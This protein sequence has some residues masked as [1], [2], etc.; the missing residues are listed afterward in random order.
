MGDRGHLERNALFS[1]MSGRVNPEPANCFAVVAC[2]LCASH[3]S[4]TCFFGFRDRL[5]GFIV[6]AHRRVIFLAGG[7]LVTDDFI[8]F[9]LAVGNIGVVIKFDPT[10]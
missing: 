9:R 2:A 10:H 5:A 6:A 7:M 4:N 8:P 1:Q 3:R